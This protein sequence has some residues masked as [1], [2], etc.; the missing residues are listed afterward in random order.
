MKDYKYSVLVTGA[1]GGGS[2]NLIRSLRRSELTLRI[3]GSNLN[4]YELGKSEAG[5]NYILPEATEP[6][7]ISKLAE[8]VEQENV[9]LVIPNSEREVLRISEER[10]Q[11]PARLFLPSERIIKLANDKYRLGRLLEDRGFPV[12]ESYRLRDY[13]EIEELFQKVVG[14]NGRVWLR[15]RT[16]SGSTGA[17]WVESAEEAER[18]IKMWETRRNI[19]VDQFTIGEFLPGRDYAFQSVWRRGKLLVGKLA[20]RLS[21]F[22]GSK[23]V[24]GMSSTPEIARTLWDGEVLTM[25]KNAVE[26]VWSGPDGPHGVISADLKGGDD[27]TMHITE[28]NVG[29]FMMITPIF[30]LSGEV[31][32]AEV[33]V[34]A[35]MDA[36]VKPV[37]FGDIQPDVY[38]LRGLDV[39]PHVCTENEMEEQIVGNLR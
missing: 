10:E 25:L 5:T 36:D 19:G 6:N 17:N 2:N 23:M 20:E 38:L 9:D 26:A 16:G 28:F 32:M 22:F 14:S 37:G 27:G 29:R 7:Y 11:V 1:G 34:K 33:Y 39:L 3:V 13:K 15:P 24:S 12:A 35:S 8:T 21:Y 18:W 31:N 4:Q 30:D